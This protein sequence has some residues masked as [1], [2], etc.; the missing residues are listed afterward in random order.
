MP[1]AVL[2]N[3]R[4]LEFEMNEG[5]GIPFPILFLGTHLK[6]HLGW[7][8][9]LIDGMTE[10]TDRA[11]RAKLLEHTKDADFVGF[12]VTTP[13]VAD[14]L[15]SSRLVKRHCP[16][17]GPILWG[18]VHPTLFPQVC[19]TDPAVDFI[20]YGEG[21]ETILE[22]ARALGNGR[23]FSKVPSLGYRLGGQARMTPFGKPVEMEKIPFPEYDLLDN[24]EVYVAPRKID[25]RKNVTDLVR[26][27]QILC[28]RG[29]PYDCTF[30][31]NVVYDK[32]ELRK[33]RAF[34]ARRTYE[35]MKWFRDRW[36]VEHLYLTDEL[37]FVNKPRL[38]ALLELLEREPLG[39]R[40]DTHSR[41]NFFNEAYLNDEYLERL[42]N[43][44]YDHF[45][46]FVESGS[47]KV[48][49]ILKKNVKIDH[50]KSSIAQS[51]R[52]GFRTSA[53]FMIGVPGEERED[54]Y[55]T[56]KLG[57]ELHRITDGN[58]GIMGPQVFR[59]Y[60]G[61][62]LYEKARKMG[63]K[64]PRDLDEW[65]TVAVNPIYG[66]LGM[67]HLPWLD[68]EKRSD[69]RFICRYFTVVLLSRLDRTLLKLPWRAIP[70]AFL[71][72]LLLKV[73]HLFGEYDRFWFVERAII[74]FCNPIEMAYRRARLW[75]RR[76][77]LDR[78]SVM[79]DRIAVAERELKAAA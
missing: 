16:N 25:Y 31:I 45:L 35:E 5:I 3:P 10:P 53:G 58:L 47:E 74:G 41:A 59:P 78:R 50:I 77:F 60:P 37:F 22:F 1:K 63:L 18:G 28:G 54:M 6:H 12:S 65:A 51:Y 52:H 11:Y 9:K 23:D 8:V 48:L 38:D 42:K 40:W 27:A 61:A 7:D 36:G 72:H 17:A 46:L 13:Q 70:V 68:D 30:C 29:C 57:I 39:I 49:Q 34:D 26:S 79:F 69:I 67:E 32:I 64:V 24:F 56:L 76:M 71:L 62:E 75:V 19:L 43:V 73:R 66:F 20:G 2:V 4:I 21:E 14:A 44:G 33:H 15:E 55:K